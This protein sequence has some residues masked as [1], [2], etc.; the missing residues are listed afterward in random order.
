MMNQ[1][2]INKSIMKALKD[3]LQMMKQ[4]TVFYAGLNFGFSEESIIVENAVL[5]YAQNVALIKRMLQDIEII[6]FESAIHVLSRNNSIYD[7]KKKEDGAFTQVFSI[8][9][10]SSNY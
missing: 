6:K 7:F 4:K 10:T 2:T 5:Q 8:Q 1:M 3:G 9:S